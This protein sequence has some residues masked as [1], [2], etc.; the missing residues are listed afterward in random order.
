MKWMVSSLVALTLAG[1]A[2]ATASTTEVFAQT[3]PRCEVES[4]EVDWGFKE[5]FRAYL[6]G[7][8]ANG[9]WTTDGDIS[10]TTPVFTIRGFAGHLSPEGDSG[11]LDA[12][13]AVTFSGH[14]GLLDQT[15]AHPR[16]VIESTSRA[17]LYFDVSGDTQEGVSVQREGVRFAEVGIRRFAVDPSIGLWS[18]EA[19]PVFLTAEGATAFGTYA[20]GEAMDPIDMR[21]QVAPA[22][23]E[24]D[25]V[26][27]QW[28]IGGGALF[29]VAA[30]SLLV[31]FQQGHQPPGGGQCAIEGGHCFSGGVF[32]GLVPNI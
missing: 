11:E 15:L 4:F 23:L 16:I 6:S 14:S 13:G 19:A 30:I 21:I 27:A 12:T 1:G 18:I 31:C 17:A 2:P 32:V 7:S 25:N 8:I 22:C 28:L 10:Y 5:S 3:P 20:A 24:R 9:E 29:A 26:V